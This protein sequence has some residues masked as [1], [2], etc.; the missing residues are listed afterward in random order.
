MRLII[1]LVIVLILVFV[2]RLERR[3]VL[4]E[5]QLVEPI[6]VFEPKGINKKYSDF[7]SGDGRYNFLYLQSNHRPIVFYKA[8]ALFVAYDKKYKPSFLTKKKSLVYVY[9]MWKIP[10]CN[11][12]IKEVFVYKENV[13]NWTEMKILFD[14][15][16]GNLMPDYPP[17]FPTEKIMKMI[18]KKLEGK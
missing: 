2:F 3:K 18:Y 13:K 14:S 9:N 7:W 17:K 5:H 12:K 4:L 15:H 6:L 16:K 11:G 1:F 10:P 8:S